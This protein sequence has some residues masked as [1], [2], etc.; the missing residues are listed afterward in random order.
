MDTAVL[1]PTHPLS[2]LAEIPLE[3]IESEI[4]ELGSHLAAAEARWLLLI[5]EFD[6]REGYLTWGMRSTAHWLNWRCGMSRPAAHERVRVARALAVLPRTVEAFSRGE[7]SYSKVRAITRV[8]TP[9]AEGELVD[10]AGAIT[11]SQLE[12]V[13]RGLASVQDQIADERGRKGHLERSLHYGHHDDG[14]GTIVVRLPPEKMALALAGLQAMAEQMAIADFV[15]EIESSA[16]DTDAPADPWSARF[17]DAFVRMAELA[18]DPEA[19]GRSFSDRFLVNVHYDLTAALDPERDGD[20]DGEAEPTARIEGGPALSADTLERL[21]CDGAYVPIAE[22]DGKPVY[23]GSK[24]ATVPRRMRR[25]LQAR[26]GGCRFPGC[27]NTHWVDAHHVI[28]RR[29]GGPTELWNLMLLCRFHHTSIHHRG[30]S[31]QRRGN[32]HAFV[33]PDGTVIP[34][35]PASPSADGTEVARA[36]SHLGLEIGPQT[37]VGE[38]D[39]SPLSR[40]GLDMVVDHL[41]GKLA[42]P[43]DECSEA[44]ATS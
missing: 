12:R 22:I 7:L 35:A 33:R 36:N 2:A 13:V 16:E 8:A 4:T 9:A 18:V 42:V 34:P 15:D 20:P 1:D 31:I 44:T 14:T 32:E 5:G 27:D 43:E 23:A 25:A 6:R 24:A 11:A 10:L 29:D 28:Y 17:A 38:W 41:I 3:R 26:D 40:F 37:I 39:G 19:A 30:F 21:L